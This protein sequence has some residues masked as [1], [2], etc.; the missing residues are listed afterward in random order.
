M[1]LWSYSCCL[2]LDTKCKA[3]NVTLQS[4][5]YRIFRIAN[6][7][8]SRYRHKRPS[9]SLLE[10]LTSLIFTS[11]SQFSFR[12]LFSSRLASPYSKAA[13]KTC[14]LATLQLCNSSVFSYSIRGSTSNASCVE[15]I[16]TL[17]TL[18]QSSISIPRETLEQR[19]LPYLF[20]T[21]PFI[22]SFAGR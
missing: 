22:Y 3:S 10:N 13:R 17:P 4:S 5:R 12:V 14:V 19:I 7:L 18:S 1:Y 8:Q 16:F 2:I 15:L 6:L 20:D 9:N 11:F 21:V